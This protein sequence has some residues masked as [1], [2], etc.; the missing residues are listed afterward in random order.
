MFELATLLSINGGLMLVA[1]ATAWALV[2][3][4]RRLKA[5]SLLGELA[6][7]AE[8]SLPLADELDGLGET[9]LRND[10]TRTARAADAIRAGQDLRSALQT[11]RLIPPASEPALAAAEATGTLPRALA[12]EAARLSK[13]AGGTAGGGWGAGFYLLATLFVVQATLGYLFYYIVPK[14]KKIFEDFGIPPDGP[15]G[16]RGTGW[17]AAPWTESL[18]MAGSFAIRYG[19]LPVFVLQLLALVLPW[20][21]A[22]PQRGG[23]LP[24]ARWIRR[25]IGSRGT[26]A[27][28]VAR[29]LANAAEAGR[30][31]PPALHAYAAAADTRGPALAALARK[32]ENGADVWPALHH[33]GLLTA[34]EARLAAAGAAAGNL[35]TVLRLT[36]DRRDAAAGRRRA[37]LLA[38]AEPAATL[39]VGAVV[40]W[41]ALAF[42]AP[43]IRL[44]HHL[45]RPTP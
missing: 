36:A 3:R 31:F 13:Q 40:A 17:L 38:L 34:G 25:W 24:G 30:P 14:F 42:F 1:V 45:G 15:E 29:A 23:R 8:R 11:G 39:L 43:L 20:A 4:G 26:H 33:A 28:R 16:D 19:I 37:R 5:A 7:A 2:R 9:L 10:R 32:V 35:P 18:L 27:S 6:V 44:I 12:E 22:R 41:I 21:L